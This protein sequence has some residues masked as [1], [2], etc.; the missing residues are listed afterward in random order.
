[1]LVVTV[2]WGACFVAIRYGLAN[3]PVLWFAALRALL[4]GAAL[5]AV[6]LALRR[7]APTASAWPNIVLL[8]LVN[9]A[10]AFAAMFAG[11]VGLTSG[12]A[13]VLANAQPLLI[14]LPAWAIYHERPH[15][16]TLAGLVVGFTGLVVTATPGGVG[17]GALLSLLA[18][19]AITTGTLLARRLAHVDVVMLAGW[20]FFLGGLVLAGWAWAVEGVPVL[21]WTPS[22]VAALLFLALIGT[23]LTYLIWFN[24][25]LR[26]PLVMLS[27]WTMLTPVFGIAFGW[28]LLGDVL[29]GQQAI[30]VALVLAALPVIL[31][32]RSR[33]RPQPGEAD[34]AEAQAADRP[35]RR[36]V[37]SQAHRRAPE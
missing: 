28:L 12:V 22:F 11:T 19:A 31:L 8:S 3:A 20:Q 15:A 27:A 18:A 13:A 29:N 1:M 4:A 35:A 34:R 9:V 21:S 10:I 14:V 17:G 24:E 6:G 2:G 37:K 7:P 26:A 33:S 25:L 23:A 5:L 32:P 30:G 16:R 36:L